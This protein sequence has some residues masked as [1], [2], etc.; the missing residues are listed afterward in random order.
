MN[1]TEMVKALEGNRA[2]LEKRKAELAKLD[3]GGAVENLSRAGAE[4]QIAS[5]T[6]CIANLEAGMRAKEYR[7]G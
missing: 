6:A 2:Q 4:R 7:N 1:R 3:R 5:L